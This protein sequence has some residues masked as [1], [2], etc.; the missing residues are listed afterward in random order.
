MQKRV[1]QEAIAL[2]KAHAAAQKEKEATEAA[3]YRAQLANDAHSAALAAI[4][5]ETSAAIMA[6]AKI[7]EAQEIMALSK[8]C[9]LYT[10]RCV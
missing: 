5:A 6:Q 1:E 8:A 2:D 9:L 10:S 4:E 3:K 7:Q